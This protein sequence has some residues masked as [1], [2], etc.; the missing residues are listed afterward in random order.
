M[1][2]CSCEIRGD[3][4]LSASSAD[5]S[6]G[7]LLFRV[8]FRRV[9]FAVSDADVTAGAE[10]V[11]GKSFGGEDGSMLAYSFPFESRAKQN[12]TSRNLKRSGCCVSAKFYLLAFEIISDAQN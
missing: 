8:S 2:A 10:I 9:D 11:S 12:V 5:S 1:D 3:F 7:L 6:W 4:G